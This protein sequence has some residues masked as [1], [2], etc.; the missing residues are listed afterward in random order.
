MSPSCIDVP[1]SPPVC[2][3]SLSECLC[4]LTVSLTHLHLTIIFELISA[5]IFCI[6]YLSYF[7]WHFNP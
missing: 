6:F 7:L 3:Q 5:I 1:Y 2:F 4:L